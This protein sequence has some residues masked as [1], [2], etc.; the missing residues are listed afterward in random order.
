M[1]DTIKFKLGRFEGPGGV[2][3]GMVAGDRVHRIG[4]LADAAWG[5]DPTIADLLQEWPRSFA[6]LQGAVQ[7]GLRGGVELD[8][9]SIVA[10]LPTPRQV[11]CCG[12]NYSK[13]VVQMMLATNVHPGLAGLD[14]AGR[15]AFA[16]SVVEEQAR[17]SDPYIFM[18][19]VSSVTGPYAEVRLPD[20]SDKIDWE[21]ELG[22]VFGRDAYEETPQTAMDA[23]AGYLVVNDLT[24]RDKVRRTDPGSIGTDWIA[25]K[26]S[27][28]FLP[29]GP[30]FVPA[31]FIPDPYAL[32]MRLSV[33]GVVRQQARTG[34]MTFDIVRQIAFL[35]RFAR[36]YPGDILCTGTPDGNAIADGSFLRHGD[37]VEAEIDGL[38]MQRTRFAARHRAS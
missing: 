11:F 21:V 20:F 17:A 7:A 38:G 15:Q 30:F 33:N 2:F 10:P 4:E 34:E 19:T 6:L 28:G 5:A 27:P 22:V 24:A 16:W 18:K 25:G 14:E 9:L 8:G 13:H 29:T 23:V 32:A 3:T 1:T 26:G 31:A 35:T 37:V 36:V 12:A